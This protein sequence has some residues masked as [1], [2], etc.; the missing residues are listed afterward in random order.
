MSEGVVGDAAD[1]SVIHPFPR[2]P[3]GRA[4]VRIDVDE[5]TYERLHGA[6]CRALDN[7]Y[8][9]PFDLFVY[10]YTNNESFVT[11]GGEPV[12]PLRVGDDA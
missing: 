1:R 10:N 6:Y 3:M 7:G 11:V 4:E 12:D 5:E 8:T 9:E 2:E